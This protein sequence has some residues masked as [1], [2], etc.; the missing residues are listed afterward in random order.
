MATQPRVGF[1]NL[2][3]SESGALTYT[4]HPFAYKYTSLPTPTGSAAGWQTPAEHN[5]ARFWA[6]WLGPKAPAGPYPIE[7]RGAVAAAASVPFKPPKRK[8]RKERKERKQ[9]KSR[10]NT[11]KNRN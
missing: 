8:S 10:K 11:R 6:S 2:A 9:R 5:S 3:A 1:S 7:A 4:G